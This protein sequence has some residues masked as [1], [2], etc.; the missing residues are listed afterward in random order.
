MLHGGRGYRVRP[1]FPL[2]I[3]H[4]AAFIDTPSIVGSC[5]DEISLFQPILTVLTHPEA[6]QVGIPSGPP[7]IAQPVGIGLRPDP[8]F[9]DKG[10]VRW[11]RIGF[12]GGRM[13]HIE[14]Q[15]LGH[16]HIQPLTVHIGV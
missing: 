1:E 10:I 7:R 5:R 13:I 3:E 2:R 6:V 8:G 9:S 14:S 16:E 4:S 15:D 11:Y 12:S